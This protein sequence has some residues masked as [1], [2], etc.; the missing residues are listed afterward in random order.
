MENSKIKFLKYTS[1]CH[2]KLINIK[3][4]KTLIKSKANQVL[5]LKKSEQQKY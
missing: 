4:K 5:Y 1:A 3:D 2:S